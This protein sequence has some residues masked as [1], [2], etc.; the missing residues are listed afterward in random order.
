[1]GK[2]W[3]IKSDTLK[4]DVA[5]VELGEILLES[6][7]DLHILGE[8]LDIYSYLLMGKPTLV[9]IERTIRSD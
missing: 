5:K 9:T 2:K 8:E 3:L 7:D 1:M 4:V 6:G